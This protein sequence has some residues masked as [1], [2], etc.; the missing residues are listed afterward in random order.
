MIALYQLLPF[1][2]VCFVACVVAPASSVAQPAGDSAR[3]RRVDI[4]VE[5]ALSRLPFEQQSGHPSVHFAS[6]RLGYALLASN[7]VGSRFT[8]LLV[9]TDAGTTWIRHDSSGPRPWKML[10]D[11][12][13]VA[14]NGLTTSDGGATWQPLILRD[15]V[16]SITKTDAASP[17][18]IAVLYRSAGV[19][20]DRL[21]FTT[22]GGAR[23]LFVD[24]TADYGGGIGI[25]TD[26]RV[27]GFPMPEGTSHRHSWRSI[28]FLSPSKL[29]VLSHT[30]FGSSNL[31]QF[32]PDYLTIIEPS[33]QLGVWSSIPVVQSVHFIDT[34]RALLVGQGTG[35]WNS[36][37]TYLFGSTDGARTWDTL[38]KAWGYQAI[39]HAPPEFPTL[40]TLRYLS[41]QHAVTDDAI[42]NESGRT[43]YPQASHPFSLVRRR[44]DHP[45][46]GV[47]G[48][49]DIFVLD[50][51]HRFVAGA[52]GLFA[53][54]SDAG[55]TWT[56][57]VGAADAQA[58]LAYGEHVLISRGYRSVAVSA[59]AGATWRD[60]G[61]NDGLPRGLRVVHDLAYPDTTNTRHII[62]V[63]EFVWID[64]TI[65]HTGVIESVDGGST[66]T[67]IA[68]LPSYPITFDERGSTDFSEVAILFAADSIGRPI[69]FIT[70]NFGFFV[71]DDLGRTWT[72]REDIFLPRSMS[73]AD[74]D[75]GIVLAVREDAV[76]PTIFL[77]SDRG[78][79]WRE[80][81]HWRANRV[82]VS[83]GFVHALDGNRSVVYTMSRR[84]GGVCV[85]QIMSTTD[86][87]VTWDTASSVQPWTA[88]TNAP[89]YECFQLFDDT[90]Y[91][92]TG[93]GAIG[94]APIGS[95]NFTMLR[96]ADS[97]DPSLVYSRAYSGIPF[98]AAVSEGR[99]Y[100]YIAGRNDAVGRWTLGALPVTPPLSVD[101][102]EALSEIELI[103]GEKTLV[104]RMPVP[105][106]DL[107]I[108]L[109]DALGRRI[110]LETIA[111]G[112][113]EA[114]IAL[115]SPLRGLHLLRVISASHQRTIPVHSVP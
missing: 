26:T 70:T 68:A 109:F 37:W 41:P 20:V 39:S 92:V 77:T 58:I 16:T 111:R 84:A 46:S 71:S 104:L 27:G 10:D 5:G 103:A 29:A 99:H 11:T 12:L 101:D 63:A 57:S 64:T 76:Y 45:P 6:P 91:V 97:S 102:D 114:H 94:R 82:Y 28:H 59:D 87:G 38:F 113:T 65:M 67:K 72:Q 8:E 66:W 78:L 105:L 85:L 106:S 4:D 50:S 95:T 21:A 3:W 34:A 90:V 86:A 81:E 25:A 80:H 30:A 23:W 35:A 56:R 89:N 18:H 51:L 9:T 73:M 2:C 112:T 36:T 19:P 47:A 93:H 75:N 53:R 15:D 42:S 17:M 96:G 24:T 33:S 62:G 100:V 48:H 83:T 74:A 108:E 44:S 40:A 55:R 52:W 22:D 110:A 49:V 14:S 43:W 31:P 32:D 54:S 79:T 1:V 7:A 107:R 13:G 60:A 61:A 115:A 69:G 98:A 88:P